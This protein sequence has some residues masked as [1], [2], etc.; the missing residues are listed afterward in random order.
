MF[1]SNLLFATL[2]LLLLISCSNEKKTEL[3]QS[4]EK[5]PDKEAI[6]QN[7]DE[8]Y[9]AALTGDI[10]K[11]KVSDALILENIN[12]ANKDGQTFLMLASFNGH[13]EVCDYLIKNGA[14]VEARDSAG[15]TALMYASTGPFASTVKLLLENGAD[16]NSVDHGEQW[17]S[18]MNAAAEGE[19]EVVKL[20][21]QFGADKN[22]KDTDGDTAESFARKK[23]HKEVSNFI[24]NYTK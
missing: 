13:I 12:K 20:L 1:K 8:Y 14:Q 5:I 19:M 21:L 9:A 24:K 7:F 18:L 11:I 6:Q 22:L 4:L 16:A 3:S 2:A 10:E 23:N 15:R 17:T